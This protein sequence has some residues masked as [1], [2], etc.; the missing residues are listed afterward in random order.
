MRTHTVDADPGNVPDLHAQKLTAL[1]DQLAV[2][3]GG[4][5]LVLE[6]LHEALG[7]QVCDAVRTHP[8]GGLDDACQLVYGEQALFHVRQRFDVGADAPAVAEDRAYIFFA[9]AFGEQFLFGL[10]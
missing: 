9:H 6:L 4:K 2:A 1:F 3:F 5:P 10:L 7:V 8:C